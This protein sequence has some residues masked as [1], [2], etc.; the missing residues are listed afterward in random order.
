MS[1]RLHK[2]RTNALTPQVLETVQAA[3]GSQGE[4]WVELGNGTGRVKLRL[5]PA[6]D[7]LE[8]MVSPSSGSTRG[9]AAPTE[10]PSRFSLRRAHRD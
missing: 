5:E 1:F 2:S 6:M 7:K 4:V 9:L 3:A 8:R 10:S